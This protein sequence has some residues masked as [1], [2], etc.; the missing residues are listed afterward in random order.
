VDCIDGF[1]TS[2]KEREALG[3]ARPAPSAV[4]PGTAFGGRR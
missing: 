2:T 1:I 4:L 3:R